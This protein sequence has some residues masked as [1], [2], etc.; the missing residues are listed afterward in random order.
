M[1]QFSIMFEKELLYI[2][3][4]LRNGFSFIELLN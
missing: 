4:V 3:N 1:F 2:V